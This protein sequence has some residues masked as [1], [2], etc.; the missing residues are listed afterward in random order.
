MSS[1]EWTNVCNINS[2]V[3][4]R[5]LQYICF[6]PT[7]VNIRGS[8]FLPKSCWVVYKRL[9]PSFWNECWVWWARSRLVLMH[10]DLPA[11]LLFEYNCWQAI[12]KVIKNLTVVTPGGTWKDPTCENDF[13]LSANTKMSQF[14]QLIVIDCWSVLFN[15]L[16][17]STDGVNLG[18]AASR[19]LMSLSTV[20]SSLQ[21][22][23][24]RV[25][26]LRQE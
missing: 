14:Y 21:A 1:F 9:T 24:F 16:Q 8:Y 11:W 22:L 6:K 5:Y 19:G 25:N 4:Q 2:L 12:K 15:L 7:L 17:G 13:F 26:D 20:A 23:L 3:T 10:P 18:G